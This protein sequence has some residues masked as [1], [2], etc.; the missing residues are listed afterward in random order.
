MKRFILNLSFFILIIALIYIGC[1]IYILKYQTPNQDSYLYAYRNKL[2]YLES[3]SSPRL[4]FV[5]G[6]NLAFGIDSKAIGDSVGLNVVNTAT[7]AGI[8]LRYMID[9]LK[10]RVRKG[11]VIVIVPEYAQFTS[12]YNGGVGNE[13]LTSVIAYNDRP[14]LNLLNMSQWYTFIL[15]IPKEIK[16]NRS[17]RYVENAFCYSARN[18]NIY[19]DEVSHWDYPSPGNFENVTGKETLSEYAVK[20]LAEKITSLRAAGVNVLLMWPTT[21]QSK[22]DNNLD[23]IDE[24]RNALAKENIIFDSRQ[25]LLVNPDSLAF[26]TPYHMSMPAVKMNTKKIID[27]LKLNLSDKE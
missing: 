20:D 19:G 15:G 18:F 8:G 27:F 21:I 5:G 23:F 6:S 24:I 22:Y 13:N 14:T 4:I 12:G 2:N 1:V 17:S 26:D 11:D 3:L 7:H 16:T 25:D 9:D 10:G